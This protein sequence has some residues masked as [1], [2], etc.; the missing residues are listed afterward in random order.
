M[1]RL[2]TLIALGAALAACDKGGNEPAPSRANGATV[3]KTAV[4]VDAFCDKHFA[5]ETGPQMTIPPVV[6]GTLAASVPTW[7]WINVW[8]TWCK[9]CVDELPRLVRWH[10]ALAARGK[11]FDL[12]FVSI[13]ENAAD[14]AEYR[15]EHPGMPPSPRLAD[16][17][18]QSEWFTSVGLDAG[19][20]V[21]IH[22][23]VR[24]SG[25]V[26]CARAG[27]VHETDLPAIEKLLAE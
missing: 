9:P 10:E 23:F 3:A 1:D 26:A 7:R 5:G 15:T 21:P 24:P 20:P 11:V 2:S 8:S 27:A 18:K 22:L 12:A 6:D 19:A 4:N 25:R 16:T 17:A 14:L 13:D